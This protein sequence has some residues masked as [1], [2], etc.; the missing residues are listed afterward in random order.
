MS[1]S[2]A[3][4]SNYRGMDIVRTTHVANG[5]IADA[6]QRVADMQ[7]SGFLGVKSLGRG[8]WHAVNPAAKKRYETE[9]KAVQSLPDTIRDIMKMI[10]EKYS[11]MGKV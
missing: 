4:G 2:G 7:D 1:V 11:A 3:G 10:Q 9:L 6:Q 8:I 5:A